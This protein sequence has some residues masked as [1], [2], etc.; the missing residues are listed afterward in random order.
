MECIRRHVY[1][2]NQDESMVGLRAALADYYKA[3]R[4]EKKMQGKLTL[5]RIRTQ[6]GWPKLKAKGAV[7]RYLAAFALQL[8]EA[9]LGER[10]QM[11]CKLL[12]R[13]YDLLR[14]NGQFLT[15][16]AKSELPELGRS[17]SELYSSLAAETAATGSKMWKSLPKL[18]L[19]Q[20][21]CEWQAPAFGN[22][23]FWWVY[24]DED[25]VGQFIDV[26][27]TCHPKTLAVTS[28]WKWLILIFEEGRG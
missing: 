15:P 22:P 14:E 5:D 28:M 8:A 3:T 4:C 6:N 2:S 20:H 7:A 17:L 13:F 25:F 18:H 19:F 1:G 11:L 12:V 21:L 23:R 10:E 26:A 27:E 16:E 9:Y 24:A